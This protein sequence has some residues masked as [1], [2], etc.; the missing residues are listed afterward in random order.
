MDFVTFLEKKKSLSG[1][2]CRSHFVERNEKTD[3]SAKIICQ[4][5]RKC[6]QSETEETP[7][8]QD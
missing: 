4:S 6:K 7:I 2:F 1:E 5:K 8:F 3:A